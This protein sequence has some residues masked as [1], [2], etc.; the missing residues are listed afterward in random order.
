MTGTLKYKDLDLKGL[1]EKCDIDFAHYTYKSDQCS[2][3]YGPKDLPKR[4]WRDGVIKDAGYSFILFKNA[5]NGSGVVKRDDYLSYQS[6]ICISWNLSDKQLNAV[7][8][9]LRKQ[10]GSEFIVSKPTNEYTC[11]ILKRRKNV[12]PPTRIRKRN[13]W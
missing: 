5:N 1:R 3:C 4:Y 7:V 13:Y 6:T 8:R 9:E 2:C 10:V 12:E 11:I